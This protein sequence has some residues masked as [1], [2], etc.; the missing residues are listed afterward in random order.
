MASNP[1]AV[2]P[3]LWADGTGLVKTLTFFFNGVSVGYSPGKIIFDGIFLPLTGNRFVSG[4]TEVIL[5][6]D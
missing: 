6:I 5:P 4:Y 2:F 3:G 1:L